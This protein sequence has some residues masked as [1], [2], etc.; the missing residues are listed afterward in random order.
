MNSHQLFLQA[1]F[2]YNL[3]KIILNAII[4]ANVMYQFDISHHHST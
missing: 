3:R 1:N 2:I 4:K